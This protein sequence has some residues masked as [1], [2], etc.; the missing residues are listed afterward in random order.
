V[1]R[2]GCFFA[3]PDTDSFSARCLSREGHSP[4]AMCT[5][6]FGRALVMLFFLFWLFAIGRI[7]TFQ[8]TPHD[9]PQHAKKQ[10]FRPSSRNSN[11]NLLKPN[12][13]G[14]FCRAP[15]G[16]RLGNS[17]NAAHRHLIRC[18]APLAIFKKTEAMALSSK[19]TYPA[20]TWPL[21]CH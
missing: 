12:R 4:L 1:G 10:H 6:A 21:K 2:G 15:K 16:F 13:A 20:L 19:S 14:K 18:S 17:L 5:T 11:S 8:T 7:L 3:R 9:R